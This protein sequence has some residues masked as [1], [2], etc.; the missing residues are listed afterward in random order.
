MVRCSNAD[1]THKTGNDWDV[2]KHDYMANPKHINK[3]KDM[4]REGNGNIT[5]SQAML[6]VAS[7]L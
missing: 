6:K 4:N 2:M 3:W 1:K 5:P 7:E